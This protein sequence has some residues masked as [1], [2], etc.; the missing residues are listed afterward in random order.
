ML[1]QA[2]KFS[3]GFL[4]ELEKFKRNME[5]IENDEARRYRRGDRQSLRDFFVYA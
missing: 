3:P 5:E 4:S 1:M 2:E